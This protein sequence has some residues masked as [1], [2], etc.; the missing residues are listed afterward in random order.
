M[1]SG[2]PRN[3][4]VTNIQSDSF[5]VKL[6]E[7]LPLDLNGI[8]TEFKI[9]LIENCR[10]GTVFEYEFYT[11]ASNV[12]VEEVTEGNN[13]SKN[14]SSGSFPGS[15][16]RR[17]IPQNAANEASNQVQ[18]TANGAQ[19]VQNTVQNTVNGVGNQVQNTANGALDG[20]Q[21]IVNNTLNNVGNIVNGSNSNTF[22]SLS[23]KN[24]SSAIAHMN[25]TDLKLGLTNRASFDF[26]YTSFD[27]LISGLLPYTFYNISTAACNKIGCGPLAHSRERTDE[28]GKQFVLIFILQV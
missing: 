23:S 13:T 20:V 21:N 19:G 16:R 24:K 1:P 6:D 8:F 12:S 15:R 7:P 3:Q 22:Q 27:I 17:G 10:N 26:R 5:K 18:N 9:S 4:E 2:P 11:V 14:A 25:L 28:T